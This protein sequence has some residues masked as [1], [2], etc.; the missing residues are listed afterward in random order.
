VLNIVDPNKELV[1]YMDAC[2]E[3]VGAIL[4]QDGKMIAYESQKLK[5]YEQRYFA[6]DLELKSIIAILI[7]MEEW[8]STEVGFPYL[9]TQVPM[10]RI[11]DLHSSL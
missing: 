1:V 11:L 5:Q 2:R 3:W 7:E 10:S 6:Y 9:F 8:M 4:T